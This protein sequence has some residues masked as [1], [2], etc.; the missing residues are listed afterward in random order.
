MWLNLQDG[1]VK[2]SKHGQTLSVWVD[3]DVLNDLDLLAKKAGITRSKI[4]CNILEVATSELKALDKVGILRV[5]L[6]LRDLE[7]VIKKRLKKAELLSEALD[8]E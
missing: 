5:T 3:E 8:L 2:K 1:T 4:V 6:F 7:E